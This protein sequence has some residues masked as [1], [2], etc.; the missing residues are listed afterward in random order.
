MKCFLLFCALTALLSLPGEVTLKANFERNQG[1][2]YS[3]NG[4]VR[5]IAV[6]DARGGKKVLSFSAAK[7]TAMLTSGTMMS[8]QYA[9]PRVR[10]CF[11]ARGKGEI[12]PGLSDGIYLGKGRHK[13]KAYDAPKSVT[14]TGKWQKIEFVKDFAGTAPIGVYIRIRLSAGGDAQLDDLILET[15]TGKG[16]KVQAQSTG[17]IIRAGEKLPECRFKVHPA[18]NEVKYLFIAPDRTF[19]SRPPA[20]ALP[21]LYRVSGTFDGACAENFISV[22][23]QKQYD[24]T[25][26]AARKI[27]FARKTKILILGDSIYDRNRGRNTADKLLFWFN[28]FQPGKVELHNAAVSG[29]YI[30]LVEKRLKGKAGKH[31]TKKY[32]RIPENKWDMILIS[33][34]SNDNRTWRKDNYQKPLV[35]FAEQK[36]SMARVLKFLKKNNPGVRLIL[37]S[38]PAANEALLEKRASA[39]EKRNQPY[40]KFG[41]PEL[42][43]QGI[44]A[45]KAAASA[46]KAE[47]LDFYEEMRNACDP[48]FFVRNDVIHQEEKGFNYLTQKI[49]EY[50]ADKQ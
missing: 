1:P 19:S 49:L 25:A 18:G 35:S 45:Q 7:K 36:A 24:Q 38:P 28:K 43:R 39:A 31:E 13:Y 32:A 22:L 14:L 2:L 44:A 27:K 4:K 11:W 10:L 17:T 46:E 47:Y 15:I 12:T 29:D 40:V 21:G 5:V 9:S 8:S 33:L 37:I 23:P 26:A 42:T 50:L 34:G 16:V 30:T 41:V 20:A 3:K 6:P 48:D